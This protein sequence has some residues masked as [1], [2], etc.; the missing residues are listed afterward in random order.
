METVQLNTI[1]LQ[2]VKKS[3]PLFM[4]MFVVSSSLFAQTAGIDSVHM[5]YYKNSLYNHLETANNDANSS[6]NIG[7]WI[8]RM[9]SADTLPKK[10]TLGS[11]FGFFHQWTVPPRANNFHSEISTPH[12][13]KWNATWTGAEKIDFVGFVPDNFDGQGFDPADTTNMGDAYERKLLYLIDQ[14][15]ENASNDNRRYV[16]YAGW[17]N[18]N[19]YGGTNADPSTITP[20]Q[21]SNWRAFGLGSYQNW[22]ELLVTRLSNAR[23][24]IDIRL[25]NINK[26]LLMCHENTLVGD[27]PPEMLF[28]DL[29][30]HGRS[31]WYF[32]AAVAEYIELYNEKPPMNFVFNPNWNVDV[33]VTSNYQTLVDYIWGVLKDDVTLSSF[34]EKEIQKPIRIYPN[35]AND[36]IYIHT[37]ESEFEIEI[38]NTFGQVII[39]EF[40]TKIISINQLPAG[41]YFVQLRS[42]SYLEKST[43]IIY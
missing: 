12:I 4:L 30:P 42:S 38:S 20:T 5:Y 28:E 3:L 32:L 13:P 21:F 17:P 6:T 9:A 18:L 39:S 40:N 33:R 11:V 19:G 25:H 31:T 35:P 34:N 26:V 2:K 36:K 15:E 10:A 8:A 41:T 22:M 23:P 16:L 29:A 1:K 14:W 24:L 43:L 37:T 7:N 27:I